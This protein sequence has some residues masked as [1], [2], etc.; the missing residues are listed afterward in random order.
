MQMPIVTSR[1]WNMV[2]GTNPDEV[3]QDLEGMQVM[4]VLGENM[5]FFINCKNVAVK[6]GIEMPEPKNFVFTNFI[7]KNECKASILLALYFFNKFI[8]THPLLLQRSFCLSS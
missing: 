5:A 2:H 6:M 3:R 1:Y 7:H 4:Q 8:S